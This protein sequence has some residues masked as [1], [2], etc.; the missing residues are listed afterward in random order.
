M[1]KDTT[2]KTSQAGFT[3]VELA[4]VMI[5][6]GLLIAGVLKGQELIGNARVTST[7][8]QIKSIDAATSTFR[9]EY[10]ALPGDIKN[11]TTRL[12]NCTADAACNA[13]AGDGNGIINSKANAAAGTEAEAF[14]PDLSLANLVSGMNT[15]LGKAA[16]NGYFPESKIGSSG[17]NVGSVATTADLTAIDATNAQSGLYL[18]LTLT[19]DIAPAAGI[20]PNQAS[21]IDQKLD[22]GVPGT[23][24][25][26]GGGATC[27]STANY[28]TTNQNKDCFLN[29][30]I[31]G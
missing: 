17:F 26:R 13:G 6:I 18:V 2:K 3:L 11:A 23:G 15:S 1:L 7:V 8:A 19:P 4:I 20:T 21:R 24:G 30:N 16:W 12:P 14:F 25:V 29:I 9:D 22:D 27:G 28:T 31:Q 5:I 10:Q